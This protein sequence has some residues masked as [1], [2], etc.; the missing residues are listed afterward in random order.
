MPRKGKNYTDRLRG[1]KGECELCHRTKPL[2]EHHLIPRAVHRKNYFVKNFTKEDMTHRRIS[3][4]RACHKGIHRLI[5][6]EK[7]LARDYNTKE[8]LLAD[9][10]IR[11][12]VEWVAKQR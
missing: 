11:R 9:E 8:K 6:D 2:T 3:I 4:C 12:H 10:R 5:P 1:P 7:E